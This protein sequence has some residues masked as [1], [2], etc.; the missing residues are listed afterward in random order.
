[1][2]TMR[3]FPNHLM[4]TMMTKE[5][6]LSTYRP[7]FNDPRVRDRVKRALD[8]CKPLLVRTKPK[9]ISSQVLARV[10]GSLGGQLSARLRYK[11]L[12][13]ESWYRPGVHSS[14]YSL[15][16]EGYAELARSVGQPVQ[17]EL[18][19]AQ[20]LYG[21]IAS[22]TVKLEYTE[23][24]PGARRYHPVQNLKKDLRAKVF[25]GWFD[26]DIEAAAPTLLYQMATKVRK[27]LRPDIAGEHFPALAQLV[28]NR[29]NVRKH[30][31]DLAGVELSVAKNVVNGLL[32]CAGLVANDKQEIFRLLKRDGVAIERLRSDPFVQAFQADMR[33]VWQ[34]LL[35][36]EAAEFE[37]A[38]S[39]GEDAVK[40][41]TIGSRRMGIYLRVER[42]VMNVIE[43]ALEQD[44]FLPILIHDGFMVRERCDV[45]RLQK[46]VKA[47]TGYEIRLAESRFGQPG[48]TLPDDP[49]DFDLI[50]A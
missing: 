23:P 32:F 25:N 39:C 6:V 13:Q 42:E 40:K 17:T 41:R 1:M 20:E 26:C 11:L 3:S 15:K 16:R 18:E 45:E 33:L 4:T 36:R 14:T 37:R 28:M 2:G 8:F 21:G 43:E 38:K 29:T 10:F 7:N 34:A 50:A 31:A 22:G 27:V 44:G 48:P 30:V 24:T 12:Q 47:K 9:R 5:L 49:L 46:A 19:V 35:L